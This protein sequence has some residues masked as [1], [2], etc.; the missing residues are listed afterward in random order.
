MKILVDIGHP[1][2]VHFFLNPIK[3]WQDMGHEMIVTS[4]VKE[5][6]TSL[7]DS[8]GTQHKILSTINDGTKTGMVKELLSRDYKLLRTVLKEKP[9]IMTGIGG[10]YVAHTGFVTRTPSI[11][12]YDTENAFLS[13]L[14]TYPFSSL[15][16]VPQCYNSW[17]PP[18]HLRYPGYHELSYLHP[19]R[20]RP[21]YDIAI[22]CGLDPSRPT[23]LIRIVAWKASHDLREKG[24]NMGI[25]E[26]VVHFLKDRGKVIITSEDALP[27]EFSK[28]QYKGL[29]EHI[30]HLM[31][32]LKLFIG[33]SATMASEC[34][35]LGV[36]SIYAAQTGRGYTDELE[37]K[38]RLVYNLSDLSWKRLKPLLT[39]ILNTPQQFWQQQQKTMLSEK[40]DVC[41]F[42]TDLVD[43]YPAS[44]SW[45][46]NKFKE[47]A[48]N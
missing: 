23:F 22:D 45:Y 13:N 43:N 36:P 24:W 41:E 12:F 31:A 2:H 8:M 26:K 19:S 42:V 7:L 9:D 17:L 27:D 16:V 10:I 21:N 25:L 33:E 40:M 28:Y 37:E 18:W 5:M 48:K 47:R 34:A 4:R 30:H 11:T 38:Y 46:A 29:P 20:F 14:I 39:E 1:A 44:T 15:V 3:K 32:Y 35:A 6:A